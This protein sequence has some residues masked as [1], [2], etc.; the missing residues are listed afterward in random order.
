MIVEA[1]RT[2]SCRTY[3]ICYISRERPLRWNAL[4]KEQAYADE[5]VAPTT[6]IS[7]LLHHRRRLLHYFHDKTN[8]RAAMT[9]SQTSRVEQADQPKTMMTQGMAV[10]EDEDLHRAKRR[11]EAVGTEADPPARRGHPTRASALEMTKE[12]RAERIRGRD[13][14]HH[15]ICAGVAP[16]QVRRGT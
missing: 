10:G 3:R 2:G 6:S 12:H 11:D 9:H 15:R 14:R 5:V 7:F 4:V 8:S 13:L 16:V 1:G